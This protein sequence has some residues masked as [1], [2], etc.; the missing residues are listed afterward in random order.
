MRA[1]RVPVRI[2]PVEVDESVAGDESPDPY[3]ERIVSAKMAAAQQLEQR[4]GCAAILVAD[5]IVVHD[6]R[7]LGKPD[8]DAHARRML[9]RMVGR[10]HEVA[11][12]YAIALPDAGTLVTETVRT[13]VWFRDLDEPAIAQYVASGEGRD[14]AGSYAIQGTGAFIVARIDGSH[15]NVIGLPLCEVVTAL[16]RHQ[17]LPALP[18]DVSS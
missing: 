18:I 3:L 12:R 9:T 1:L 17:L 15:S 4:D 13:T 11:G 14:K 5:T 10:S 8:D 16:Q 7:V 6:G 2:V